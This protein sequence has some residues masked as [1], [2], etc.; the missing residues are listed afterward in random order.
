MQSNILL[1]VVVRLIVATSGVEDVGG[2]IGSLEG[3]SV[4]GELWRD[5]GW[6][7]TDTCRT[8]M[9]TKEGGEDALEG[10]RQC[11]RATLYS[12]VPRERDETR[13]SPR[14]DHRNQD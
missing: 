1:T 11:R 10:K 9:G 12:G 5:H 6:Q 14:S 3:V 2:D 8:A 4:V 7:T 13:A